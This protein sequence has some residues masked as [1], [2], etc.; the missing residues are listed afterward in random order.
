[1]VAVL[2]RRTGDNKNCNGVKTTT[3]SKLLD[4]VCISAILTATSVLAGIYSCVH[5]RNMSLFCF[6][7]APVLTQSFEFKRKLEMWAN[8]QRDGRPA[9]YRWRPL[10]NAAKFG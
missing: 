2:L 3:D 1:M 7:P 6:H 9:E 8:A 10:F 4:L 5:C